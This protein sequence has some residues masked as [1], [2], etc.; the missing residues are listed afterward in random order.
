[1]KMT[2]RQQFIVMCVYGLSLLSGQ[3]VRPIQAYETSNLGSRVLFNIPS[4][5]SQCY[6]SGAP[7]IVQHAR[8]KGNQRGAMRD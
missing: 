4:P 3:T 8:T 7:W 5:I 6:P 1:M 2:G